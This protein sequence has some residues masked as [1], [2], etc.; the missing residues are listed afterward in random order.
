MN[1]NSLKRSN[2]EERNSIF[3]FTILG[4]AKTAKFI[5]GEGLNIA[6]SAECACEDMIITARGLV[7]A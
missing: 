2:L 6:M 4:F 7:N 3:S 1:G 5:K